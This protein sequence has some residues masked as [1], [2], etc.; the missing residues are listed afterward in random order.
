MSLFRLFPLLCAVAGPLS[1]SACSADGADPVVLAAAATET[2][3]LDV[4]GMTCASCAVTVKTA[5]RKVDGVS[6]GEV[7][8]KA[9]R[10]TV[11]YDPAK[12]SADQIAQ[13]VTHAGYEAKI[14]ANPES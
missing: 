3:L 7:D 5:L 14:A 11:T 8:V 12:A 10:V 1:L 4:S 13:A 6:A 2:A 9:D